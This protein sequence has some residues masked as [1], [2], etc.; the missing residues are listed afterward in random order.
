MGFQRPSYPAE[1]SNEQSYIIWQVMQKPI[2]RA[3]YASILARMN[4]RAKAD[5]TFRET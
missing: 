2:S 4:L 1:N 5:V 3:D